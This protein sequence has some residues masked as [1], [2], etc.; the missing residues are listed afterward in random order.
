LRIPA[1]IPRCAATGVDPDSGVRDLNVV[2]GL[3]AA[4][5]HYDM[6]VYGEVRHAG[7]V[8]VGDVVVPPPDPQRRS[9][10]GHWLR[11]FGFLARGAPHVLS[12]R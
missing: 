1:R 5:G 8:A 10:A 7:R 11:F 9:S 12:R 6:G 3:K 2:K 4:Y